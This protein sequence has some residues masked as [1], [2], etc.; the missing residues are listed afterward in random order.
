MDRGR[1]GEDRG[2]KETDRCP[3]TP[4]GISHKSGERATEGQRERYDQEHWVVW[5]C[6]VTHVQRQDLCP[7]RH[8]SE[9]SNHGATS[10]Y[11]CYWT[12]FSNLISSCRWTWRNNVK[13]IYSICKY[14]CCHAQVRMSTGSKALSSHV[15][16]VFKLLR[17]IIHSS[18]TC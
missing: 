15:W 5:E 10:W 16:E 8:R 12:S 14:T 17:S 13:I 18:P 3:L 11:M 2:S 9:V 4:R 6:R 1:V 7:Q